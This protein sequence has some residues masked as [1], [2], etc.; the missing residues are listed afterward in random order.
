MFF[1]PMAPSAPTTIEASA[2]KITIWRQASAWVPKASS[3]TRMVSAS[4]ATLGA[5]AKKV[6]T[7]VGAPS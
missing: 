7:G 4:A 1:W 2:A 6:V 3:E 5:V